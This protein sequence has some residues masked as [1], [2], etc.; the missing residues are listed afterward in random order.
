MP[1]DSRPSRR[2]TGG[3]TSGGAV[4]AITEDAI[5]E[6]AAFRG[7]EA[8]VTS[9]YLNV[10]GR[11]HT[12][13]EEYEQ[14]LDHLV[15]GAKPRANGTH[16]VASDLRRITEFVRGG[17]DR[18]T[19]RGLAIFSCTAHDFWEVVLLPVPVRN[20]VVIQ[21]A[22]AVS[23]LERLVN[24]FN[25]FGV[26]LA[27]RQR[28]RMFVFEMGEL[29]DHSE[30]LDE[31]PRDYDARGEKDQGDK[32]AHVEA[33][34]SQH[35][36]Q[37]AA[38]AFDLFRSGGFEH[39]TIGCPDPIAH[40][41]ESNLHPYLR[42]RLAPRV[43]VQPSASLEQIRQ[44]VIDLELEV[45]RLEEAEQ[46][47]RLRAAVAT[48]QRGVA[49][50][51]GVLAALSE[52][53]VQSLLVS[54]GF[55]QPGWRCEACHLL[56]TVGRNCPACQGEMAQVEDAVEEAL[57]DALRQSCAVRVCVG[58]ADLDVLGRIGALLRY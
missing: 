48:S 43:G 41:L 22:P 54:D 37:A 33:L 16:S 32:H 7:E 14:E 28:A 19:T 21:S 20:K 23:Q 52:H 38:A 2:G 29:T 13:R 1:D 12:R 40:E 24:E 11:H 53:R 35:L 6:L 30:R 4:P 49:G 18:S 42:E 57:D 27:D 36:R 5:R 9:C 8:P 47:D 51:P 31:L 10:D 3:D 50:L 46:V 39:F 26:L 56:T 34:A 58:N 25:R 44:A 17:I 55:S 45:D 15:R